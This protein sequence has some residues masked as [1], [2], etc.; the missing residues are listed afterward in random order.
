MVYL[1]LTSI[2]VMFTIQS[3]LVYGFWWAGDIARSS[4]ELDS[5]LLYY[6]LS[7]PFSDGG[8]GLASNPNVDIV[9]SKIH[10]S[11]GDFLKAERLLWRVDGRVGP[12][13]HATMLL[14]QVMQMNHAHQEIEAFYANRLEKNQR[15]ELVWE[16]YVAWLKREGQNEHAI[17]MSRTAVSI[18]PDAGRLRLQNALTEMQHGDAEISVAFFMQETKV[19]PN[20]P[21]AWHM[22]A[23]SLSAAGRSVEAREAAAKASSLQNLQSP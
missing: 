9:M 15:W 16:D 13:A 12:D 6:E 7:G 23:R 10:E 20:N 3:A 14:G 19:H 11:R 21:N 18:N 1:L 17:Q 2:V 5:A 22:L 4:E 8:V